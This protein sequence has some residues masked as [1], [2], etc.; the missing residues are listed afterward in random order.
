MEHQHHVWNHIWMHEKKC[1]GSYTW[2]FHTNR[3]QNW[4][5]VFVTFFPFLTLFLSDFYFRPT[6]HFCTSSESLS[7]SFFFVVC[8]SGWFK[9]SSPVPSSSSVQ[10]VAPWLGWGL[11]NKLQSL[12][13]LL[14]I[15]QSLNYKR[16]FFL[17][18]FCFHSCRRVS[19]FYI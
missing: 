10:S 1:S 16:V 9:H 6:W 5:Q 13:D 8:I 12:L 4:T 14:T 3:N 17:E 2:D 7:T 19:V 15:H 11:I 18:S